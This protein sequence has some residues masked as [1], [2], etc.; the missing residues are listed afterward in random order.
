[1]HMATKR[2]D[3]S[4]EQF[5]AR[6]NQELMITPYNRGYLDAANDRQPDETLANTA[7]GRMHWLQGYMDY[8]LDKRTYT[9][10]QEQMPRGV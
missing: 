7:V 3:E 8:G 2:P 1:M 10:R 4:V 5:V 6:T 9:P